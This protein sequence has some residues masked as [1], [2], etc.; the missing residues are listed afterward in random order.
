VGRL[1][2]KNEK[3]GLGGK[4]KKGVYKNREI[5]KKRD[6]QGQVMTIL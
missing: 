4:K 6:E 5:R 2:G 3:Q 1:L